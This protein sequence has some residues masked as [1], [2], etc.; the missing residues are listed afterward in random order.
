[1]NCD[2]QI[3]MQD[4]AQFMNYLATGERG[5]APGTCPSPG[6]PVAQGPYEFMDTDCSHNPTPGPTTPPLTNITPN[7][8]LV[9]LIA[10]AGI[11]QNIPGSCPEV[12][13][14]FT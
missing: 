3:T 11:D 2:D 10:I 6:E 14:R 13:E 7:D 5:P 1:M 12:G 8:A 4:F 9:L